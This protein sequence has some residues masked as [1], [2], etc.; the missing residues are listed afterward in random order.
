MDLL[1]L[2]VVFVVGYL[3]GRLTSWLAGL[4]A[5][6]AL[7]LFVLGLAVPASVTGVVDSVLT[8]FYEGNELLFLSGFLF[9]VAGGRKVVR[10][11]RTVVSRRRRD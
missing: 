3:A 1:A 2:L 11:T 5:L 10:Q 7:G 6:L 9:G 4:A 8:G